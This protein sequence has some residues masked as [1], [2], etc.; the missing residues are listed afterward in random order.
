MPPPPVLTAVVVHVVVFPL[1]VVVVVVVVVLVGISARLGSARLARARSAAVLLRAR[2]P[3][4]S[5]VIMQ[6]RLVSHTWV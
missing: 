3:P 4:C 6:V 5:V 1:A 2:A